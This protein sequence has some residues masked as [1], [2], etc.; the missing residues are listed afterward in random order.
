[1]TDLALEWMGA[2]RASEGEKVWLD[3]VAA[4]R[5]VT[6]GKVTLVLHPYYSSVD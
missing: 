4:L 2:V 5:T 1:M 6:E 3:W